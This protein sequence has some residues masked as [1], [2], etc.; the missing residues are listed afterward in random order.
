MFIH[1]SCLYI[2]HVYTIIAGRMA[3]SKKKDFVI[4][5]SLALFYRF[6]VCGAFLSAIS[7]MQ[8]GQF[9]SCG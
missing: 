3:L 6:L 4:K 1:Y 8:Y 5:D 2:Y 9:Y 7:D